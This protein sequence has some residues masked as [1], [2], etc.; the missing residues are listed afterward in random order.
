[1]ALNKQTIRSNQTIY[2]EGVILSKEEIIE[3]SESWNE[4]QTLFFKKMLKQ[5]GQCLINGCSFKIL[6]KQRDDLD[7]YGEKP[8]TTPLIPGE[9]TF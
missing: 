5:G 2:R 8:K 9:R 4:N 1:M 6:I 3:I 7:S